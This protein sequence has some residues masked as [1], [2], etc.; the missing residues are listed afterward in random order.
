MRIASKRTSLLCVLVI[1]TGLLF[2][3]ISTLDA[4]AYLFWSN[5]TPDRVIGRADNDGSNI[6]TSLCAATNALNVAAG[7]NHVY[8][9]FYGSSG[10]IGRAIVDGSSASNTWLSGLNYNG[11]MAV[12]DTYIYWTT[13]SASQT[14]GRCNLDGSGFN[15]NWLSIGITSVGRGVAVD[16]NYIYWTD[17]YLDVIMRAN[18]D[19]TGLDTSWIT[20]CDAPGDVAVDGSYVYWTNSGGTTVGRAG[21]N[22]SGVDQG[23][24]S[25]YTAPWGIDVDASYVYVAMTDYITRSSIDGSGLNPTWISHTGAN[26]GLAVT[27]TSTPVTLVTFMASQRRTHVKVEWATAMEEETAGFHV[28]RADGQN[29]EFVRVTDEMIP[30]AGGPFEG[31]LYRWLDNTATAGTTYWYKLEDVSYGGLST[32]HGPVKATGKKPKASAH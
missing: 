15:Q 10:Y 19:G 1:L 14:I 22:G 27:A 11:G 17:A 18:I 28:W 16:A 21:L 6:T 8:W 24:I 25:G 13:G 26:R 20:G 29:K 12:D 9:C 4:Q 7:G 3:V 23:W 31:V 5:Y 2:P 30:A 32:W